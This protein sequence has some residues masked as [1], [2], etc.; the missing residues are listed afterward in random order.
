M[1]DEI[2]FSFTKKGKHA[3]VLLYQAL[4]ILFYDASKCIKNII[5]NLT[6]PSDKERVIEY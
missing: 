1:E 5:I 3:T 2:L 4:V 6:R